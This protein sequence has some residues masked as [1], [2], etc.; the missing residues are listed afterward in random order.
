MSNNFIPSSQNNPCLVC[1]RT[2]DGDCRESKDGKTILCHTNLN[3]YPKETI[4]G[5]IWTGKENIW[6]GGSLEHS[7]W[8]LI[9]ED[10][11]KKPN[12]IIHQP[13][14]QNKRATTAMLVKEKQQQSI[15]TISLAKYYQ[16]PTP[17]EAYDPSKHYIP[18]R[19]DI[20]KVV[21]V[22]AYSNANGAEK[23]RIEYAIE[24]NNP[25][26]KKEEKRINA[27][28]LYDKTFSYR[29]IKPDGTYDYSEGNWSLYRWEEQKS[30]LK[31]NE[32]VLI[33]EGE[34]VV[35]ALN[36]LGLACLYPHKW[37]QEQIYIELLETIKQNNLTP[38]LLEDN[39]DAGKRHIEKASQILKNHK[40]DSIVLSIPYLLGI[41]KALSLP[42]P[43]PWEEAPPEG[44]DLKDLI[45]Y[46]VPTEVD[47]TQNKTMSDH[48]NQQVQDWLVQL[49][50]KAIRQKREEEHKKHSSISQPP[51]SYELD[52][53]R[54]GEEDGLQINQ[55]IAYRLYNGYIFYQD[56]L[57]RKSSD[58]QLVYYE[59]VSEN[60]EIKRITQVLNSE[61]VWKQNPNGEWKPSYPYAT[62]EQTKKCLQWVKD[63]KSI[64]ILP[65]SKPCI[66]C[67]NGVLEFHYTDDK[68]SV[69]F[70][71]R[72][73]TDDD[74]CLYKPVVVYDA[75]ADTKYCDEF[76][77][78]V[79]KPSLN[80]L[81]KVISQSF[82][83]LT[84]RK[85]VGRL[86]ALFLSGLGNNGK[87]VFR[88]WTELIHGEGLMCDVPLEIFQEYLEGKKFGLADLEGKKIN[89]ASENAEGVLVKK[90]QPLKKAITGEKI[91][92][93]RKY[94]KGY[95]YN[96]SC[97]HLFHVNETP[98]I[99]G[100]LEAIKS[101]FAPIAFTK[102]YK[103]KPNKDKGELQA[104]P[105]FRE[106]K[107]FI[108]E[109]I[110]PAYLNYLLTAF[111][112]LLENGID[113][114]IT[115]AEFERIQCRNSYLRQFEV[116]SG[117]VF[118]IDSAIQIQDLWD[119]LYKYSL[120]QGF[121]SEFT[122]SGKI[123]KVW[124]KP[125][126][127]LDPYVTAPNQVFESFSKLFPK[128]ERIPL[129][130]NKFGIKG[131]TFKDLLWAE[132]KAEEPEPEFINEPEPEPIEQIQEIAPEPQQQKPTP[133]PIKR[134]QTM[135]VEPILTTEPE[136][137][138][139]VEEIVKQL[140]QVV[141]KEEYYELSNPFFRN[142]CNIKQELFKK[143]YLL[144]P[145]HVQRRINA[146]HNGVI[147]KVKK[148]AKFTPPN[149][150]QFTAGELVVFNNQP[151][152]F[153]KIPRK[154]DL[155]PREQK[156]MESTNWITL[157]NID[158]DLEINADLTDV[159]PW[160][161]AEVKT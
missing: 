83:I 135:T 39:D 84:A 73:Y 87:D 160:T 122:V 3:P 67:A 90:L 100:A 7:T 76:F 26:N 48:P 115:E 128:I 75:N 159:K 61:V 141:F 29:H 9:Q 63:I 35:D 143:A 68:K 44:V 14:T 98:R 85:R 78:C 158:N 20:K 130:H 79:D 91:T 72:D 102:T 150:C 110:L 23:L 114:S 36:A 49:L 47:S 157:Q 113:Y 106:D 42:L 58:N 54:T 82:D 11:E 12:K 108:I 96:P 27:G 92:I 37:D 161:K 59:P 129:G 156:L 118:N 69:E 139:T 45:D 30:S 152:W 140:E 149:W 145:I 15:E 38:I 50:T 65:Q 25:L 148:I 33:G 34:G 32:F 41:A 5:Y 104:N 137:T 19:V 144:A 89:W 142:E 24:P 116:D 21:C 80:L 120:E 154:Q 103:L 86:V 43:I 77:T 125:V 64:E 97:V 60:A 121:V 105:K 2:K 17:R 62:P 28:K 95:S 71:L 153:S 94:Q 134:I 66:F 18:K 53:D 147:S 4:N 132:Q 111:K 126:N 81:L 93:E 136:P 56:R 146:L 57:W 133:E 52:R 109:N 101:R 10:W 124:E 99:D 6:T 74:Y 155:T 127:K 131:L 112:D 117:L 16:E 119:R 70:K 88:F 1:E 123:K 46:W 22:Y 55:K 8:V 51:S 151:Y 40:I 13:L 31:P 138:I 107:D